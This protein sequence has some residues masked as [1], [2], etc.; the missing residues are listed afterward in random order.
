MS[1]LDKPGTPEELLQSGTKGMKWGV[2]KDHPGGVSR[3]VDRSAKKDAQETARA[4]MF[5]GEGAGNRRKLIKGAVEGK[6]KHL[7]GYKEAF[8]R[9]L[10]NQNMADH[11]SKAQG[12]RTRKN[13]RNS[14][15]K[16]ARGVSHLL[17][18]NAQYASAAAA[19]LFG[20]AMYIHKQGIDKVVLDHAKQSY[21][22]VKREHGRRN[23]SASDFLRGMGMNV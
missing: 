9:H 18:G 7:P 15:A 6:S 4:K 16:T 10:A 21:G 3:S 2:R 1:Y 19:M 11:A 13:V 5:Y 20:G 23:S 14:T 17:R 8:D 12:E 22:K